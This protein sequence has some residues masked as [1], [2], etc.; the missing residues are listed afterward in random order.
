MIINT[1][2]INALKCGSLARSPWGSHV[3][4][5]EDR[6]FQMKIVGVGIKNSNMATET[7]L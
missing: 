2:I 5:T 1:I 7:H 4:K 6:K 3:S